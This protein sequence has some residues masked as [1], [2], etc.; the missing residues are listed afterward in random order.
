MK[1][2]NCK[3]KA[4][5]RHYT[6]RFARSA[7]L[8]SEGHVSLTTEEEVNDFD[9]TICQH[10]LIKAYIIPLTIA[11]VCLLVAGFVI[12]LKIETISNLPGFLIIGTKIF[13]GWTLGLVGVVLIS[14]AIYTNYFIMSTIASQ[15]PEQNPEFEEYQKGALLSIVEKRSVSD[16]SSLKVMITVLLGAVLIGLSVLILVLWLSGINI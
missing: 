15:V 5:G 9:V 12:G 2:C 14:T 13:I 7:S 16:R 6:V 4:G 8:D 11:V 1:K 3:E 10:C